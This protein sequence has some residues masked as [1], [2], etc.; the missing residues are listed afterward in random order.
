M[1]RRK[2][3]SCWVCLSA[4][5]ALLS[6]GNTGAPE[7]NYGSLLQTLTEQVI[8][9][10]HQDFATQADALV[11]SV[12]A[13]SDKPSAANLKAAQAAWREAR[14]AW[15][16]LD[17]V[18]I[19]PEL[20]LLI[21]DRIDVS[22]V[23]SGGIEA[24]VT[25]KDVVDD[26]AVGKAG[27][28]KKGFFGLEYLLFSDSSAAKDT[29]AP[30]LADDAA[31]PRRRTWAISIADEI[32][33]SA[34]DLDNAW[35]PSGD[36]YA[37]QLELAGAGSTKYATQRAAVDALVAGGVA[38]ALEYIVGVRLA[39]P[40]GRTSGG[41]PDPT[42]DPT[43]R[44]DSAVADM[45]ASLSGVVALYQGDGFSALVKAQNS[46]LDKAVTQELTDANSALAAIPAPFS[47][48]VVNDTQ[49]VQAAYDGAK[50]LK[51]TWNTDVS[52]ALGAIPKPSD[53][54]GD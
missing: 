2:S 14:R 45:Q 3:L 28:K 11:V 40:L 51:T 21:Q 44:S 22:P 17:A 23:D 5:C 34:H 20:T 48:A 36:N 35:E 32:A 37:Q 18:H 54:D 42:L 19:G 53:P 46:N 33:S 50:S 30:A 12:Q 6:C 27:G 38:N 24:I 15:R 8:L 16:V 43:R 9:P 7:R 1:S 49:A 31:A 39:P 10:E 47:D 26:Q 29:P 13:L 4:C 41:T 52:S 25:G